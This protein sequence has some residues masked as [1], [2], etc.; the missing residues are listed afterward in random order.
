MKKII[1]A[2][3]LCVLITSPVFAD[4]S[5][6][7]VNYTRI[8]GYYAGVGGEFTLGGP[9]LTLDLSAYSDLTKNQIGKVGI[10]SFQTFCLEKTEFVAQPMDIIVSTTSI[11][12]ATG[13]LGPDGSGSHAIRG[14][15]VYGDNL[16][17]RT[18][19]LYTKFA[20]GQLNGY[21]YT[22]GLGR[23][24]SAR[25]LQQAFWHLEEEQN[26]ISY[27]A[28]QFVNLANSAVAVGGEWYGM[29]IG[30]VRILNTFKAG[31]GTQDQIY[32][33][34]VPGAV[35]LGI[36]GLGAA[37]LKLRRKE[38]LNKNTKRG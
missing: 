26:I 37:G 36:L 12:E 35:L 5:G 6:G 30:D 24:R 29:G 18:A 22:P 4:Y 28:Q 21:R 32:L 27:K 10:P 1:I 16:D 7:R 3:M 20:T 15:K 14:S 31:G 23:I 9:E 13:V 25:A 2:I 33:V 8:T 34:P 38:D 11:D 17:T 19:F